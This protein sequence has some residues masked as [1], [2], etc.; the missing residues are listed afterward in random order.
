MSTFLQMSQIKLLQGKLGV[1]I[2]ICKTSL[3]QR[4]VVRG[5]AAN[6]NK[7]R[8]EILEIFIHVVETEGKERV[9]SVISKQVQLMVTCVVLIFLYSVQFLYVYYMYV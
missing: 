3:Q 4:I 7:A 1:K 8:A 2:D 9:A 5:T 6:T